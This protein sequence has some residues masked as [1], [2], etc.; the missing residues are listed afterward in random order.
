MHE[1]IWL[2]RMFNDYL[3]GVGN[4]LLSILGQPTDARPWANFIVMQ[5]LVVA[6]IVVLFAVL[7]PRLSVDRPGKV[8][9]TFELI[10]DFVNGQADD[11]VGHDGHKHITIFGTLFIFILL[12]NLIGIIPGFE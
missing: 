9:Q 3:A 1:E 2:T 11:M 8:Q 5:L 6:I 4:L 12:S 7:K 10:Y